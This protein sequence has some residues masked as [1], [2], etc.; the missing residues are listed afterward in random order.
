MLTNPVITSTHAPADS[1]A[2]AVV[3]VAHGGDFAAGM[4][5]FARRAIAGDIASGMRRLARPATVG[6]FATGMLTVPRSTAVG[7]FATGMRRAERPAL[8]VVHGEP[9]LAADLA[10][11][12]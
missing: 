2:D 1:A 3:P 12:A 7:D 9:E 11:A 10:L 6:T 8:V 5:R 4:R